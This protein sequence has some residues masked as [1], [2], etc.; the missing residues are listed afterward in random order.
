MDLAAVKAR[1]DI[2][3]IVRA[4]V[5]LLV[6]RSPGDFWACC[7]FHAEDTPSFH[8]RADLGVFKC[9][10]CGASGDVIAFVMLIHGISFVEA[11]KRLQAGL[12]EAKAPAAHLQP[13]RRRPPSS[14]LPPPEDVARL[15]GVSRPVTDDPD[16]AAY[17]RS[18]SIDPA[19][20]HARVT[21]ARALPEGCE[22]PKWATKVIEPGGRPRPWSDTDYRLLV[23]MFRPGVWDP[24]SLRARR[25]VPGDP[26][27][28]AGRGIS[29]RGQV[30]ADALGRY[31]LVHRRV[32]PDWPVN[33]QLLVVIAE[34]EI[35]FL[36]LGT[37]WPD[38][39]PSPAVLGVVS[40]SW[41]PEIAACIP[42]GAR[43]EIRT[44]PDEAG[45]RMAVGICAT[46]SGRC[47]V[48]R[49]VP[50]ESAP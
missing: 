23:P 16:V 35:D 13:A 39:H 3:G 21:L 26:K 36:T 34:G 46:F 42:D 24:C 12:G 48:E 10:G 41:T 29:T 30:M 4:H 7:P 22:C 25:I 27:S 40:G 17:L 38:E 32:P 5:Q 31:L 47:E 19:A 15:L 1:A 8:V 28:L 9:F 43:I 6:E 2:V 14:T 11:L 45:D 49:V 33:Q 50:R 44:D 18:R 20:V 37:W